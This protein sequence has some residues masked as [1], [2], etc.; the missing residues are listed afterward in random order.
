MCRPATQQ[1][2][3]TR[4]DTLQNARNF[5]FI[6]VRHLDGLRVGVEVLEEVPLAGD[7]LLQL[8][9][10]G[11]HRLVLPEGEAAREEGLLRL[12]VPVV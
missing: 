9:L 8:L 12:E 7:G 10:D 5:I 2:L 11:P 4:W 6:L 3:Q 1:K